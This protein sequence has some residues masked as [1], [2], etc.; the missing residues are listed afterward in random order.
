MVDFLPRLSP[1]H[2]VSFFFSMPKSASL[3][4]SKNGSVQSFL[5]LST[6]VLKLQLLTTPMGRLGLCH[7]TGSTSTVHHTI[8]YSVRLRNE[9]PLLPYKDMPANKNTGH[10]NVQRRND[11]WV[12]GKQST[13]KRQ[14]WPLGVRFSFL[15][16]CKLNPRTIT[17]LQNSTLV[18]TI[19][20]DK[21]RLW[22]R[23]QLEHA[24][25]LNTGRQTMANNRSPLDERIIGSNI[26][27]ANA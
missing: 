2:V 24:I 10:T 17:S 25:F 16:V 3:A 27:G 15:G 8:S 7:K 22:S 21:A 12:Q 19:T 5:W 13:T 23:N 26:W 9:G 4:R 6:S 1:C 14:C 20:K 11:M 18:W